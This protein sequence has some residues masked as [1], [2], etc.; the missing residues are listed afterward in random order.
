MHP[1]YVI[2]GMTPVALRVE[3]AEVRL[4]LQAKL[5]PGRRPCDLIPVT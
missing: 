1:L 4:L 3:V 5:D 2:A